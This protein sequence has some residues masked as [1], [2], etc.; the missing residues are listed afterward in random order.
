MAEIFQPLSEA[1]ARRRIADAIASLIGQ[2]QFYGY[3]LQQMDP[4]LDPSLHGAFGVSYQKAKGRL[5]L[6]FNPAGMRQPTHNPWEPDFDPDAQVPYSFDNV[7]ASM[8]HECL[9]I[10]LRHLVRHPATDKDLWNI[11]AD[12]VIN[13]QVKNIARGRVS[14]K[15]F[16]PA[17]PPNLPMEGYFEIL[18]Q[19][20]PKCPKHGDGKKPET[21]KG[22]QNGPKQKGH[23][24]QSEPDE[25]SEGSGQSPGKE[26]GEAGEGD[27]GSEPSAPGIE[28]GEGDGHGHGEKGPP[29]T[30]SPESCGSEHWSQTGDHDVEEAMRQA[31]AFANQQY[32]RQLIKNDGSRSQGTLPADVERW[33]E[34]MLHRPINWQHRI[35]CIGNAAVKYGHR[36]TIFRPHRRYGTMFAGR[37]V[38]HAGKVIVAVDTSGS[39]S[40]ALLAAFWHEV[41]NVMRRCDVV[42]IECDAAI[43]DVRLLKGRKV[44]ALKGGG[45]SDF[46]GVFQLAL[47]EGDYD[48]KWKA[49]ASQASALIF[50]TDGA[51]AVPQKNK[52]GLP[53]YWC[54]PQGC[55]P[56]TTE[57]GETIRMSV[58]DQVR[59]PSVA[60]IAA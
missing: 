19:K 50:L 47:G 58:D 10:V 35:K 22:K 39:V 21:Q 29:C 40:D 8:E 60:T 23:G 41:R 9:H 32:Q 27:A 3:L 44:P 15:M 5:F 25:N 36:S 31:V 52:T 42:L 14:L 37:K 20:M 4:L 33:I 38:S 30:C 11:A 57:Y 24:Q 51:I 56:P 6:H 18:K 49:L 2:K 17:L 26:P 1:D 53:V 13:Q 55:N 46:N 28:D 54:I 43:H 59:A 45:G 16:D 48:R 7:V 34:Q 12:L